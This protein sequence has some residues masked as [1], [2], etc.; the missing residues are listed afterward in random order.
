MP[1]VLRHNFATHS[2]GAGLSPSQVSAITG[3]ASSDPDK[4][5]GATEVYMH[6][7]AET[8]LPLFERVEEALMGKAYGL[9]DELY[10]DEVVQ[11]DAPISDTPSA[12]DTFKNE[13]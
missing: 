4:K 12:D 1:Q 11:P 9:S 5:L 2:F 6:S 13:E 3:H 8:N 7:N 10:A